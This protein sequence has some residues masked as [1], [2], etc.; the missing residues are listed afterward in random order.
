MLTKY[1]GEIALHLQNNVTLAQLKA[2]L[3]EKV[4]EGEELTEKVRI[5][6]KELLKL[7]SEGKELRMYNDS[8]QID[9]KA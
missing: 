7:R 8:L 6:E 2:Q 3:Q 4:D 5:Q 1:E 9:L